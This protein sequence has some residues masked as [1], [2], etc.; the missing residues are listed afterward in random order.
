MAE[1]IDG[2]FEETEIKI[3]AQYYVVY[4]PFLAGGQ[5]NMPLNFGE[6]QK[7]EAL[8]EP[9]E[10]KDMELSFVDIE[11][12]RE[13]AKTYNSDIYFAEDYLYVGVSTDQDVDADQNTRYK[14]VERHSTNEH[15]RLDAK[16]LNKKYAKELESLNDGMRDAKDDVLQVTP[17]KDKFIAYDVPFDA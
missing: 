1:K 16:F 6:N 12:A 17:T 9:L 7:A 2:I 11:S 5:Y 14:L 15:P 8:W 4:A 3:L 10:F 13:L